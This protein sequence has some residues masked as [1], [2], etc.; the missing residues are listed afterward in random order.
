MPAG[1]HRVALRTLRLTSVLSRRGLLLSGRTCSRRSVRRVVRAAFT[2]SCRRACACAGTVMRSRDMPV[3]CGMS[4]E[5]ATAGPGTETETGTDPR[6]WTHAPRH[7]HWGH[8]SMGDAPRRDRSCVRGSHRG[9]SLE[10]SGEP[11]TPQHSTPK[12]GNAPPGA[13]THLPSPQHRRAHRPTP[14]SR[15]A[16]AA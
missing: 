1:R 3:S 7:C 14:G 15:P 4:R 11:N 9:S 12:H 8:T 16:A 2:Y 5:N 6:A 13:G 10:R